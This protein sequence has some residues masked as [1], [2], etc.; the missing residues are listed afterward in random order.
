MKKLIFPITAIIVALA[1]FLVYRVSGEKTSQPERPRIPVVTMM[2]PVYN[3]VIPDRVTFCGEEVPLD[4]FLTREFLD[5]ELTVNAYFHSSTLALFKKANRWFPI[6]EP[7][8]EYYQVPSDMKYL[9]LIES[10]LEN[11]VSPAGAAGFWQLMPTTAKEHGLEV[12]DVIDER[13]NLEKSTHVACRYLKDSYQRFGSWTL[14]AAAY[15]TGNKRI[16]EAI[17]E[18][19][20]NSYY[21]LLLNQETARYVFRILAIKIIFENPEQYGYFLSKEDLYPP[22]PTRTIEVRTPIQNLVDFAQEHRVTYRVL[23]Y[24]NP[25]LRK[26]SLPNASGKIYQIKLP[27]EGYTSYQQL[28]ASQP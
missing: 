13:Y 19:K 4:F 17:S 15:N 18:Q 20:V 25:W 12:N 3:V 21:D 16:A 1:G 11:T 6:I 8:L 23:K 27:L 7:I 10:N 5:R 28:R 24:F 22:I 9:A 26:Q 2:S 14:A